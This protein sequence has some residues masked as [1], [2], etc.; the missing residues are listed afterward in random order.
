MR[1]DTQ[2]CSGLIDLLSVFLVNG[3]LVERSI[4]PSPAP[5]P[6]RILSALFINLRSSSHCEASIS[7]LAHQVCVSLEWARFEDRAL[8]CPAH[9]R[10]LISSAA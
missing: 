7:L 6:L 8:S 4:P 5:P 1:M 9:S 10:S 2:R 3:T